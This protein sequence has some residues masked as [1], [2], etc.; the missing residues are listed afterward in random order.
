MRYVVSGFEV[1][2]FLVVQ[3]YTLCLFDV[4]NILH[5]FRSAIKYFL[6]FVVFRML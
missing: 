3:T 4:A 6:K 2:S 1:A 5:I